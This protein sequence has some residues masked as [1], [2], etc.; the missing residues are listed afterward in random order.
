[1]SKT[2][3]DD[4][5]L[6]VVARLLLVVISIF[7]LSLKSPRTG[8]VFLSF[9]FHMKAEMLWRAKKC[10]N[11]LLLFVCLAFKNNIEWV[12]F[13]LWW[14]HLYLSCS[15]FFSSL[16]LL[17]LYVVSCVCECLHKKTYGKVFSFF[18]PS[19]VRHVIIPYFLC[20]H[21]AFDMLW[22]RLLLKSVT[23]KRKK[24]L[25]LGMIMSFDEYKMEIE[26][27]YRLSENE[28]YFLCEHILRMLSRS[29]II[30]FSSCFYTLCWAQ[31]MET[32]N[33]DIL[34][35]KIFYF[36]RWNCLLQSTGR[37]KSI[38]WRWY[39]IRTSTQ[40]YYYFEID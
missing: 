18:L 9:L 1:M 16:S 21:S 39:F 27:F 36:T 10:E 5:A 8:K 33:H 37:E 38:K 13:S 30:Y 17:S 28:S 25:D 15:S 24:K 22:I 6:I 32:V 19:F 20:Y 12:F 29:I 34:I 11:F 7:Y 23:N 35:P 3:L 31:Q 2:N 26:R 4:E 14:L 40:C